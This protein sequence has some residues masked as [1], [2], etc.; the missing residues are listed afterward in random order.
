MLIRTNYDAI[1]SS[2]I[3]SE[4]VYRERRE[5]MKL[6][7]STVVL[8]ASPLS[9]ALGYMKTPNN[10]GMETTPIDQI[11]SYNNFYEFALDKESPASLAKGFQTRPWTLS[12][13]GEVQKTQTF[14]IDTLIKTIPSKRRFTVFA[15]WRG[16]RWW[17]RG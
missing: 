6:A 14:D 4:S 1:P 15:A 7:A 9:A 8:A 13:G 12:L 16:G 2:Q 5:L 11:T 10:T 3:T 17:Y